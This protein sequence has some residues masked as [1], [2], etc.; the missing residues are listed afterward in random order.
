VDRGEPVGENWVVEAVDEVVDGKEDCM[1]SVNSI[2][3]LL[4]LKFC[5]SMKLLLQESFG[6]DEPVP[7]GLWASSPAHRDSKTK[8]HPVALK[9]HFGFFIIRNDCYLYFDS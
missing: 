5:F 9:N 7:L 8:P 6:V 1:K 2:S 3:S 4:H